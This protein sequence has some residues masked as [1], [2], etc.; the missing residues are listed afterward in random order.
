VKDGYS[1]I[2]EN[3]GKLLAAGR[4]SNIY[5]YGKDRVLR[6]SRNG[7]SQTSEAKTMEFVRS[8]GFPVP[9][10][11]SVSDDGL[12]V[13]MARIVGP[14]MIEAASAKPWKLKRFGRQ[15][16]DLHQSLHQLDAPD[17]VPDAPCGS[18]SALLHMDFHPLNIILSRE[19]PVVVDWTRA[20][21]GDP[22]VD[23]AA[24]W[25]LLAS[26]EVSDSRLQALIVTMGRKVLLNSYLAP[27]VKTGV[28]SVLPGVVEWKCQDPN[29]RASEIDR[30]RAL[31]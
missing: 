19:G 12:D 27:F 18:G 25:V 24:T 14:T 1:P 15:L 13:V 10:V 9:E 29:M 28:R 11:F 26:G 3:P 30:M 16:A 6:R 20:S 17:W 2:V 21:R 23:V 22:L 5:E 4:D 8:H 7:R 31:L